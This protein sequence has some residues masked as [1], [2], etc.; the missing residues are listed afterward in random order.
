MK[1]KSWARFSAARVR[2]QRRKFRPWWRHRW[3]ATQAS[4]AVGTDGSSVVEQT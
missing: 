2:D 3:P 1:L 4:Q